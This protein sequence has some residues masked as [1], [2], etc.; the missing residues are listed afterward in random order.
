MADDISRQD[1]ERIESEWVSNPSPMLCARL[2]DTLRHMGRLDESRQ[3]ADT[4]LRRWKNN[5]SITVVLAKCYRDSGLLEKALESFS[6]VNSTQPQNLVALVNLAEIHFQKENWSEA[7]NYF[8][9]YLFEHPG[10]EEAR[11]KLEEARSRKNSST[12]I[13]TETEEDI[14]EHED[15][16]FPKTER[17]NKVL[18]SQGIL[19][20]AFSESVE[21][22][23]DEYSLEDDLFIVGNSP[24]S[25]L[26]FFS[27]EECKS[28]KLE[29]Y[30]AEDE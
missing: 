10:D 29:S 15:D 7:V 28:L 14:P 9:E 23:S 6:V 17:M 30:D 21:M 13:A 12:Q 27:D 18:E 16:V 11:D 22:E 3:V 8:E 24:D 1:L 26:G 4:G 19:K 2:A 5:I 25:L 20:E